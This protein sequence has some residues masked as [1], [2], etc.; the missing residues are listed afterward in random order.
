MKT[1]SLTATIGLVVVLG[2]GLASP[3][4]A[5]V[6]V[7]ACV[8]LTATNNQND[9]ASFT[10]AHSATT[11]ATPAD[12]HGEK[13][14]TMTGLTWDQSSFLPALKGQCDRNKLVKNATS[15][16]CA[17]DWDAICG[18][19]E[20]VKGSA[21]TL[22]GI[23]GVDNDTEDSGTK[24]VTCEGPPPEEE[25]EP[26]TQDTGDDTPILIS[27][28]PGPFELTSLDD[29]VHFDINGDGNPE[30][31]SW[32]EGSFAGGFLVLDRNDNGTIDDGT[33]L[34][35]AKTYQLP[36]Q[37]EPNGFLA[38]AVYDAPETGGNRDGWLSASDE[39][40]SELLLWV[41]ANHD[42]VSQS[43]ELQGLRLHGVEAIELDYTTS[44]RRDRHGNF[45]RW[46]SRVHFEDHQRFAAADVIFLRE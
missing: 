2:V 20:T 16:S 13:A 9:S 22:A 1:R 27:L 45:L 11:N 46:T 37:D 34:F 3:S 4:L 18:V 6:T 29:P 14:F 44:G 35:G 38:L 28:E 23:N 36:A 30:T 39:V 12:G 41:D 43:S 10:G 26:D 19:G 21:R 5:A 25:E 42:G 31:I 7:N 17:T 15:L 24:S 33:E 40:F 8:T 32:T